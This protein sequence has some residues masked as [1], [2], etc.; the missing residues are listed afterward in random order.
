[1]EAAT[2]EAAEVMEVVEAIVEVGAE[3]SGPAEEAVGVAVFA[4][5]GAATAWVVAASAGVTA[6][7]PAQLE[8]DRVAEGSAREVGAEANTSALHNNINSV[9]RDNPVRDN[10]VS[11]SLIDP[12][13]ADARRMGSMAPH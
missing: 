11:V 8:V 13:A 9:L 6:V 5:V 10:P 12:V 3:A 4:E 7:A 1:M 2:V